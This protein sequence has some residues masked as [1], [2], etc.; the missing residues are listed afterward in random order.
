VLRAF[1]TVE[2]MG[3]RADIAEPVHIHLVLW[4]LFGTAHL[5]M[6]LHQMLNWL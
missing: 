1:F 2:I 5:L 4:L 6:N 3:I